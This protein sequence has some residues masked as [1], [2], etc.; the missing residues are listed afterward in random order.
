MTPAATASKAISG[1]AT[2]VLFFTIFGVI[3]MTNGLAAIDRL[4]P[5]TLAAILAIAAA[6]A[7]PAVRLLHLASSNAAPIQPP[8]ADATS[9][10]QIERHPETARQVV[11][12]TE[13]AVKRTFHRVNAIQ[14][15][16]ILTA[17]LLLNLLHKVEYLAP[18]ITFIVGMHLFPLA[19]LFRYPAH[20]ATGTLLVLWAIANTAILPPETMPSITAL[21]TAAILLGS[22]ASTICSATRAARVVLTSSNLQ[23]RSA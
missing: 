23:P 18:V 3:W 15:A 13:A 11:M 22:A 19:T 2:G 17:I 10:P 7:I 16:A 14:W 5:I 8:S 9:D 12:D 4:N 6:L 20:N 1:R 21:G